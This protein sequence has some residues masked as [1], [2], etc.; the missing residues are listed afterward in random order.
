MK[1]RHVS[2][3]AVLCLA[4]STTV[5]SCSK[6]DLT[7]NLNNAA[8]ENTDYAAGLVAASMSSST[9]ATTSTTSGTITTAF[10]L[11]YSLSVNW[12]A[13]ANG[14]YLLTQA[15]KDFSRVAYWQGTSSQSN[16]GTLR[17]TLLRNALQ[18]GGVLSRIDIPDAS[19]YR[20]TYDIMFASDFDFSNGGKVGFGMLIGDGQTGSQTG[21]DG[22]GGSFRLG[23]GKSSTGAIVLKPNVYYK[24]QTNTGGNDLGKMYPSNGTSL[25]KNT[26]YKV[27]MVV[28][29]NT[30]TST[31]GLIQLTVNGVSVLNQSIRWTTNDAKRFVNNVC[32]ETFRSGPDAT[33]QSTTDGNIL[34]DN[35]VIK[36]LS[37]EG[38]AASTSTATQTS[39]PTATP[40]VTPTVTPTAPAT[41]N[42][43]ATRTINW[44]NYANGAAYGLT[45]ARADF[46]NANYWQQ[47]TTSQSQVANGMLRTTLQP[48]SLTSGGVLS[49]SNVTPGSEYEL[50]YDMQFASNFDFSWGGKVGYGFFIGEGN[51]GGDAAWDGNGGSLRIMWYKNTSTSPIILK[52]YVYYK[53]QPGTYG[54]DFGKKF[55]A[56]G[57][58]IQKGVW[59]NVKM[60]IK[61][62]TGSN[63]DGRVRIVINGT[64]ILDQAIRWTT[65]DLKRM[66]N[67]VAFETFRGGGETYWQSSTSGDI[68]FDNLKVTQL[69]L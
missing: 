34:F 29:S 19:Y 16:N 49:R 58:S 45:Q 38:P 62:N 11:P 43:I 9:L 44:N 35:V 5:I 21:T 59:Y 55:P 8:T 27:N 20:L 39:T 61:S 40:T 17:T 22:N 23:W 60:Y 12:N 26:W 65:N 47:N 51:T 41:S 37:T 4:L 7:G 53:D 54:D 6:E 66:V 42:G 13:A 63:T 30:G 10:A 1:Q 48:N 50:S 67:T 31:N 46:G 15:T 56:D 25:Q 24:D 52:P 64:T 68:Y 14:S 28:K 57:S 2:G 33:Y 18:S 36:S 69:A 3:L 32:F